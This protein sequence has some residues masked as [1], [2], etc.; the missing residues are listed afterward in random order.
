MALAGRSLAIFPNLS[1]AKILVSVDIS[2]AQFKT[3]KGQL[4]ETFGFGS[5]LVFRYLLAYC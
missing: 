5:V 4:K 3:D 1:L 2:K